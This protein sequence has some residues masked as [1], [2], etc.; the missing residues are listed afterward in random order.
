M[1]VNA[2]ESLVK[3]LITGFGHHVLI[4]GAV[5]I[6]ARIVWSRVWPLVAGQQFGNALNLGTVLGVFAIGRQFGG[7]TRI[8][9][10]SGEHA[11]HADDGKAGW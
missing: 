11:A 7:G 4:D 8:W 1:G 5:G 2:G 10:D 9:S 3:G 6:A